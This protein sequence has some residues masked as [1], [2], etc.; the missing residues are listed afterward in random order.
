[1]RNWSAVLRS[2]TRISGSKK[3]SGTG[4]SLKDKDRVDKAL[5]DAYSDEDDDDEDKD[6]EENWGADEKVKKYFFFFLFI[7]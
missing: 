5:N 2:G 6:A 3:E 7:N 4:S 1:M